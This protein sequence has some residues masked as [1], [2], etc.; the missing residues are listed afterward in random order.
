MDISAPSTGIA[1]DSATP[2]NRMGAAPPPIDLKHR[3]P[4][5]YK[6]SLIILV[7][8]VVVFHDTLMQL[9]F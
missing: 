4:D 2:A 7:S 6:I 9:S 8:L 3:D 1:L 5:Y